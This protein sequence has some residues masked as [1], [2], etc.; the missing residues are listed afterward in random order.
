MPCYGARMGKTESN[1]RFLETHSPWLMQSSFKL[2]HSALLRRR[3][4]LRGE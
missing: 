1:F 3:R 2:Q 4:G